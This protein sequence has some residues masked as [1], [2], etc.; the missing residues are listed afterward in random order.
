MKMQ[1]ILNS[2]PI[3][4][5]PFHSELAAN[6]AYQKQLMIFVMG[7]GG[8]FVFVLLLIAILSQKSD[9]VGRL[10]NCRPSSAL[11]W[12]DLD[13]FFAK[14]HWTP[15]EST[16]PAL[17]RKT[18]FGGMM[19]VIV[20][21]TIVLVS[22]QL[23][24]SN[25][26][27][28]YTSSVSIESPQWQPH[29]SYSLSLKMYGSGLE[30]CNVNASAASIRWTMSD[31]SGTAP[32]V[33]FN[34]NASDGSCIAMWRCDKCKLLSTT[35]TSLR[36]IVSSNAF[37]THAAYLLSSPSFTKSATETGS[38]ES[39][40]LFSVSGVLSC[41]DSCAFQGGASV[42]TTLLTVFNV[43]FGTDQRI[44]F[45]PVVGN[46]LPGPAVTR[47]NHD[48]SAVS[49]FEYRFDLTRN[50]ISIVNIGQTSNIFNLVVLWLSVAGSIISGF[51]LLLP[52]L[53]KRL[54]ISTVWGPTMVAGDLVRN[55]SDKISAL[56]VQMLLNS[57]QMTALEAAVSGQPNKD[58][59]TPSLSTVDAS[60]IET[61]VQLK[62]K[63]EKQGKSAEQQ[64]KVN[65][66][67]LECLKYHLCSPCP[68]ASPAATLL[69]RSL[70]LAQSIS[71]LNILKQICRIPL[72]KIFRMVLKCHQLP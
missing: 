31:W 7:A 50:S 8:A 9:I 52:Q 3:T 35:T 6:S 43:L 57:K 66:T 62:A 64:E 22:I 69:R 37:S 63:V 49:G 26:T 61:V 20:M 45:Q 28:T 53:E 1:E 54:L 42:V 71:T 24:I 23:G 44:A 19:S 65:A 25:L 39:Q 32:V 16:L 14:L 47:A 4:T 46:I 41:G 34:Y 30:V 21:F 72:V 33:Q 51:S 11:T 55:W 40:S 56:E 27:P 17:H 68:L 58:P 60:L 15:S 36:V 5:N 10:L 13:V 59:S 38:A 29:G 67:L 18:S 70:S 48:F 12:V 2:V